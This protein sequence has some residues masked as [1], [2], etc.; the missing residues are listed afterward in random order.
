MPREYE[1]ETAFRN[2]IKR[3][4]QGR[5]TVTTVDFVKELERLNWHFSLKEANCWVEI[6]TSTFRDVSTKEGEERT[7]QVFNP[8]GGL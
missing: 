7:F 6:Y 8:N 4:Q 1:K 2:A 3:D 5:Y